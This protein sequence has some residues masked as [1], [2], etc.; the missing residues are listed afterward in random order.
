M[1]TVFVMFFLAGLVTGQELRVK[2][3]NAH[4]VHLEWTGGPAVVERIDGKLTQALEKVT[5][6]GFED[7]AIDRFGTYLHRDR[8]ARKASN[9]VMVGPPPGGVTNAVP[10]PKG[11]DAGNFGEATA[12][13]LVGE[14]QTAMAGFET[15]VYG[16]GQRFVAARS[17]SARGGPIPVNCG[18]RRIM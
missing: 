10:L 17:W 7:K 12:L 15:W 14:G 9:E 18:Y 5:S 8:I 16:D 6:S 2:S 1:R 11:A 4:S 13:A 3:A